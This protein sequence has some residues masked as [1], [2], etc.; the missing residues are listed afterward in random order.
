MKVFKGF[1]TR[2]YAESGRLFDIYNV[3]LV[4]EDILNEI[5]TT[6]GERIHMPK[7]GT[8]IPQLSFEI[9]DKVTMDV[10]KEDILKVVNI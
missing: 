5:F 6:Y 1:S 10:I 4:E 7:F 3:D 9:N 2:G 8:R